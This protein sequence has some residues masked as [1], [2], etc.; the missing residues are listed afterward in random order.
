MPLSRRAAMA[1]AAVAMS[2]PTAAQPDWPAKP[3]R[4]VVAF[5]PGSIA[6]ALARMA[7][8]RLPA[9]LPVGGGGGAPRFVIDNRSGAA[10]N[11]G[12]EHV[13]RADPDGYT[14]GQ[15]SSGT[16][17]SNLALYRNVGYDALA[18]FEAVA[19][20]VRVPNILVVRNTLAPRSVA[21]F[22]ARA[23]SEPGAFTY[24]S[25]G[26]GSS[27]HL[28][29]A[30]FAAL[31]GTRLTHVPY[32]GVPPL[33]LDLQAD[34]LDASFQ[35]VPNVVEQVRAGQLRALAVATAARLPA[36]P[37]VPTMAEAGIE[38][39]E[40]AGW[41]GLVA[42]RG[43][44]VAIV[45]RM[46]AAVQALLAEPALRQRLA[47]MGAEPLPLGPAAFRAFIAAEIPRWRD[48]VRQSGA[49]LD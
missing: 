47:A 29:G 16:H 41:F 10:G 18:D 34:R 14:F 17:A 44:P 24:G 3:V 43:T 22:V 46:A 30:Q 11:I 8:E 32:R 19:G 5:P 28:A 31:T 49:Q 20:L 27:Q 13:A 48:I 42:P 7:A 39:F 6:D 40:T 12:M 9:H 1:A 21:E 25:I 26:N 23:K 4:L 38:G 2:R 35:L 36:L 33:I 15:A 37:E 45:D